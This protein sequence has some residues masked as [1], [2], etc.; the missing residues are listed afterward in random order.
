MGHATKYVAPRSRA[1]RRALDRVSTGGWIGVVNRISPE[2][3]N[4]GTA[5][6]G[7]LIVPDDE[8][9]VCGTSSGWLGP[10]ARTA[11]VAGWSCWLQRE[12]LARSS[13]QSVFSHAYA[14]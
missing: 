7:A 8:T 13:C 11:L 6:G 5:P 1:A 14:A 3:S 9:G 4:D 2:A 10:T 12:G